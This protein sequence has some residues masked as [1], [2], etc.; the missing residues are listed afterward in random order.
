MFPAHWRVITVETDLCASYEHE[1]AHEVE[2]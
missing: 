1:H 2:S